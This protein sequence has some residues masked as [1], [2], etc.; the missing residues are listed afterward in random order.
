MTRV[1]ELDDLYRQAVRHA[2]IADRTGFPGLAEALKA[3][4][5]EIERERK[6]LSVLDPLGLAI[7]LMSARPPSA[8]RLRVVSGVNG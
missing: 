4:A 5:Y 3:V 7:D 1:N 6:D 2:M 8:G